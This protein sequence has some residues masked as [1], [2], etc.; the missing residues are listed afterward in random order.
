MMQK[1]YLLVSLLAA[2]ALLSGCSTNNDEPNQP[3]P[4]KTVSQDQITAQKRGDGLVN[5]SNETQ[6][7]L[8]AK[9][10]EE[11][12]VEVVKL[13]PVVTERKDYVPVPLGE[14][15]GSIVDT[16]TETAVVYN[17]FKS[18]ETH[19]W[20]KDLKTKGW[21]EHPDETIDNGKSYNVYLTNGNKTIAIYATNTDKVKNTFIVF[22]K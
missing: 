12:A 5:P 22:S 14:V 4:N 17:V 21:F 7:I 2:A 15:S 13:P 16:K 3:E 18:V 6:Q 19:Q 9:T 1:K 20:V 10:F 11:G 8:P